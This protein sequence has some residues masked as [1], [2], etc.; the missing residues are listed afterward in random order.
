ML[1]SKPVELTVD[2]NADENGKAVHEQ[3]YVNRISGG[4]LGG[5]SHSRVD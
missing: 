2:L 1:C 5:T 4:D 3:C